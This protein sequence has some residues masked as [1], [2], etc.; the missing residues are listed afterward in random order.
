MS[1]ASGGRVLRTTTHGA[2]LALSFTGR[3]VALFAPKGPRYGGLS[4]SLDGG[5]ETRISLYHASVKSQVGLYVVNL[6][7]SGPHK[8]V[9]RSRSVGSRQRADVDAF[10]VVG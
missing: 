6:P 3:S 7:A 10:A 4:I 2:R 8:L 5:P 1:G 9:I